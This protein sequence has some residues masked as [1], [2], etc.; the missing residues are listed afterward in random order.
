MIHKK[1]A[2]RINERR[3]TYKPM[4]TYAPAVSKTE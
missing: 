2:E 4:K 3:Q 1:T